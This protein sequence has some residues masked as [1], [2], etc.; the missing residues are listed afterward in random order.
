[1]CNKQRTNI[2]I[3]RFNVYKITMSKYIIKEMFGLG[4]LQNEEDKLYYGFSDGEVIV[5]SEIGFY[6][7]SQLVNHLEKSNGD[8][9]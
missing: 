3:D 2:E 7:L 8:S 6:T 9:K 5:E 4:I 1:M